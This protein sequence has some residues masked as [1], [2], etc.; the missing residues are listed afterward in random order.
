MPRERQGF[1]QGPAFVDSLGQEISSGKYEALILGVLQDHK[2]WEEE[3]G[4]DAEGIFVGVDIAE[5]YG[6]SRSFKRG[7]I[8][9]AQEAGVNQTDVEFM[10]R[11][12]TVERAAGRK[13]GRLIREHYTE[14][15]QMLDAR[16]RFSKAL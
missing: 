11:W 10:G 12:R 4:E 3:Q 8:T 15:V 14:L 5:V 16:L 2:R 1:F 13:P 6:I 7:D 9:R